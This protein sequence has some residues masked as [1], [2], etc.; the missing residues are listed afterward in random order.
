M[1][2]DLDQGTARRAK[3]ALNKAGTP[4]IADSIDGGYAPHTHWRVFR[5]PDFEDVTDDALAALAA[6]EEASHGR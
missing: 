3:N 1:S 5:F 4:C 2:D 6:A